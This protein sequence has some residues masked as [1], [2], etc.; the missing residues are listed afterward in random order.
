[1]LPTHLP[2][3][4]LSAIS[5]DKDPRLTDFLERA[6]YRAVIIVG[7]S[8][9]AYVIATLPLPLLVIALLAIAVLPLILYRP[10][11]IWV[12]LGIMLPISSGV[13]VGPLRVT[14]LLLAAAFGVWFL[15]GVRHRSLKAP[16]L[17]LLVPLAIY[18][19]VLYLSLL[20]STNRAE[21][22]TELLKWIQFAAILSTLPVMFRRD[23]KGATSGRWLL[24]GLLVAGMGQALLGIYQ[25]IFRIGPE[26]FVI[27][28]RFMRASGSFHQPN[29]YAGYLGLSLPIA[30]SLTLGTMPGLWQRRNRGFF[31]FC[32]AATALLGIGLL[33]SWSRGGWLGALGSTMVVLLLRNRRTMLIGAMLTML[34]LIAL[35]FGR[36][37]PAM[38]PEPLVARFQNVPA[39]LG[40]TDLLEQPLTNEN[41]AIIER[42]AHW[43][44]ALRMWD[45][46]PWLGVG[47][48]NYATIYPEVRL[49]RWEEALGH[50]HN[51]YLNTLA[52]SG[53]VGLLAYCLLWTAIAI[54]LWRH[55]QRATTM[56]GEELPAWRPS[57]ILGA[58][59]MLCHLSIHN[60]FDNLFVQGNYLHIALWLALIATF[61]QRGIENHA[62]PESRQFDR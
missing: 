59:G 56:V 16:F 51:I 4:L 36:L 46:A 23:G 14:D 25:F 5:P 49:P 37:Q 17:W 43:E 39:Y 11:L 27:M 7:L 12:G 41:F 29:P 33:A 34:L 19:L 8:V 44:A 10:W 2:S 32:A 30:L 22:I 40:M 6:L 62:L 52:E 15:E 20:Q 31:V 38:I 35:L 9:G 47:P 53:I 50:A 18:I 42:L 45:R 26:W 58:I 61:A 48:G 57:L 24:V 54:W 55:Y 3:P 1:M 28:G 13:A 60:F 21:A